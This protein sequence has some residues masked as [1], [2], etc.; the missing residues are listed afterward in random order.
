MSLIKE[1]LKRFDEEIKTLKDNI[2]EIPEN[3]CPSIDKVIS[4]IQSYVKD[5]EYLEMNVY[6]YDSA[7]ELV[8]DFPSFGWND[9]TADLDVK[10]RNDNEKLR[11]LG[12]FWYEN[13]KELKSFLSTC[14]TEHYKELEE[15]ANKKILHKSENYS[16]EDFD[17]GHDEGYIDALADL[18]DFIA[19]NK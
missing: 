4:D 17:K 13:C 1:Q 5:I 3:T 14:I 18:L 10:L 12:I 16:I 11:E 6:K 2:G 9:P 19:K 8:K 7:E 15:W